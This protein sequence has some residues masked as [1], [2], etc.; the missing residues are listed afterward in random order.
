VELVHR[1]REALAAAESA[2]QEAVREGW[3]PTSEPRAHAFAA[4]VHLKQAL[5]SLKRK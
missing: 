2:A 1:L 4:V 5:D 3:Y